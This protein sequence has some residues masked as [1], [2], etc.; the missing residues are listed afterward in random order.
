M[1][2]LQ[3]RNVIRTMTA[4]PPTT[5]PAIAPVVEDPFFGVGLGVADG[6]F[7]PILVH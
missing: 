4:T 2:N 5:P 7:G 3:T 1:Q 6:P